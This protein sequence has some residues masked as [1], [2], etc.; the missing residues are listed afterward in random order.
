MYKHRIDRACQ[1]FS[2]QAKSEA[3]SNSKF[4]YHNCKSTQI[5][6]EFHRLST[7]N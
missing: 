7:K 1:D 3:A 4:P 6:I 5:Q 2:D